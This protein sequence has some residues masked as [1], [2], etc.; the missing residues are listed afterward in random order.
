MSY[1]R[2]WRTHIDPD[3]L[4]EY[5]D[6][7]AERSTPMFQTQPGCLGVLFSRW[8]DEVAVLSFWESQESI[9][10][11][12]SSPLYQREVKAIGDSGM[13]RDGSTIDIF[14]IHGGTFSDATTIAAG[15]T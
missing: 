8:N 9:A 11:L 12:D 4:Q 14:E 10:A 3:R 1:V 13:L 15:T 7:A 6:F 5:Q 2:I